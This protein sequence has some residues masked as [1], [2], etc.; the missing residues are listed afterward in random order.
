MAKT[1]PFVKAAAKTEK[2]WTLCEG[3]G[4]TP[5]RESDHGEWSPAPHWVVLMLSL[6]RGT[7]VIGPFTSEDAAHKWVREESDGEMYN[8][9]CR[10]SVPGVSFHVDYLD[11]PTRRDMR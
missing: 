2:K 3:V 8:H 7:H 9:F 11:I 5:D 4:F 1:K 6:Q 10:S